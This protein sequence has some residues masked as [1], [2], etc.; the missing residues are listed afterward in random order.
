MSDGSSVGSDWVCIGVDCV[1]DL[2]N[3]V[4]VDFGF[5]V[6]GGGLSCGVLFYDCYVV[7]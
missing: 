5:C 2:G 6:V 4:G 1:D 7:W 3:F